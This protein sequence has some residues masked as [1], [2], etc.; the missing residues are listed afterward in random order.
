MGYPTP[1]PP[2]DL[3]DDERLLYVDPASIL[4]QKVRCL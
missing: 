3:T 4:T 2:A 1:A